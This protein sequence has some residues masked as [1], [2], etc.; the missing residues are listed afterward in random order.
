MGQ[1]GREILKT[2]YAQLGV[3]VEFLEVTPQRGL[4][5]SST[6]V[7]DGEVQRIAQVAAKYPTLL[8]IDPPLIVI[9]LAVFTNK[10]EV[11]DAGIEGLSQFH[12]G[13]LSG[14][15]AL[16]ELTRGFERQWIGDS[17]VELFRML[18]A[19][20]LE[21]VISNVV[22]AEL[23]M[24]KLGLQNIRPERLPIRRIQVYHY[25]HKKNAD[26]AGDI[27]GVLQEMLMDGSKDVIV[28]DMVDKMVG[29]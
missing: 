1:V 5:D 25:L 21:A 12:V 15:V 16:E 7:T 17:Q 28:S 19:G 9:E 4:M 18:E 14:V 29:F 27:S 6:G 22:V 20:R 24:Q 26:L 11:I 10:Q 23:V 13:R 2:A 3:T 8:R